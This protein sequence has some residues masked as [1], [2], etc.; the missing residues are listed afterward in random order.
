MRENEWNK[1]SLRVSRPQFS[2]LLKD[3]LKSCFTS[4]PNE[5]KPSGKAQVGCSSQPSVSKV[6]VIQ[7][8]NYSRERQ[9]LNYPQ[10]SRLLELNVLSHIHTLSSVSQQGQSEVRIGPWRATVGKR[11]VQPFLG[12]HSFL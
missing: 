12:R 9:V 11:R 5:K 7:V 6:S 8:P 1:L 2:H 3:N 10:S 4:S